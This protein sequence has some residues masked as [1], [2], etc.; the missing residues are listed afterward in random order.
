[1]YLLLQCWSS[2]TSR[3]EDMFCVQDFWEVTE[4]IF[5]DATARVE[6]D[7]Q[8]ADVVDHDTLLVWW[9]NIFWGESTLPDFY[10]TVE[11]FMACFASF[12]YPWTICQQRKIQ[13]GLELP[14]GLQDEQRHKMHTLWQRPV[15]IHCL[16]FKIYT[17]K[18]NIAVHV[19][20]SD[21]STHGNVK[22]LKISGPLFTNRRQDRTYWPILVILSP[23]LAVTEATLAVQLATDLEM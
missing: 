5:G 6:L 20:E 18:Y 19:F 13:W 12:S 22:G 10:G 4:A 8:S 17:C 2:S 21:S 14:K 1:M 3:G 15:I 16:A 7:R 9:H 23:I 11:V